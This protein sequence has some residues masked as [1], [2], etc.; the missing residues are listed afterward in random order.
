MRQTVGLEQSTSAAF[1]GLCAL[2]RGLGGLI[3]GTISPLMRN[4]SKGTS[5]FWPIIIYTGVALSLSS[6]IQ[7]FNGCIVRKR[8]SSESSET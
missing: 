1:F 2:T 8:V 6:T 7:L 5:G 4:T 3:G